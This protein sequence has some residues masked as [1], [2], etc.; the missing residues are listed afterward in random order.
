MARAGARTGSM[1]LHSW[2]CSPPTRRCQRESFAGS[3]SFFAEA[4]G[5]WRP[6][7]A[8]FGPIMSFRQYFRLKRKDISSTIADFLQRTNIAHREN[9]LCV[10]RFLIRVQR[11][12][13]KQLAQIP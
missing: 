4:C 2:G 9:E 6:G 13:R 1:R 11:P 7:A 10:L 3:N 8:R 5:A 12:A